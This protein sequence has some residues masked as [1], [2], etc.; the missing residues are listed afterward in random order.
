M[1]D[2]ALN[3][4]IQHFSWGSE[5]TE[6]EKGTSTGIMCASADLSSMAQDIESQVAKGAISADD[7][8]LKRLEQ[9]ATKA[10]AALGVTWLVRHF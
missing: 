5:N 6:L 4:P 1:E 2:L 3:P 7:A 8:E 10:E 9:S